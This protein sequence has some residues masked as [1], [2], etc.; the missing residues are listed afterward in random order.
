M[1]PKDKQAENTELI[2]YYWLE[3]TENNW[4]ET[5]YQANFTGE[6][7]LTRLIIYGVCAGIG[8]ICL[9][10]AIICGFI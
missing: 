8:V 6:K 7:G 2:F 5:F 10:I 1:L 4:F 9:L 3:G